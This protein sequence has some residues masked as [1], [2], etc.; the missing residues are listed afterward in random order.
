MLSLVRKYINKYRLLSEEKPVVVGLSGG[1]DSVA[2]LSVLSRLGYRCIA[3]H[4]NFHLR[5]NEAERDA[6]FACNF[7]QTLNIPFYQTGFDTR[8][9]AE[10]KHISV[11]MAARELRYRWF[12]D[13]RRQSDAQAIAVAHH[14]DDNVETFLINLLR[15]AGVRGLIGMRP[16]N[17]YIVRPLLSVS[18]EDLLVWLKE[19]QLSFI[20]DSSNLSDAYLRN[21]LRLNVLPLLEKL[22]PSVKETIAR[23]S[24]HL[25]AAEIIYRAVVK[26]A[27]ST[28]VDK[29]NRISISA[30][31]RFPSPETIL[32]ELL[33]PFHF[34]RQ[35]TDDICAALNKKASGKTFYS[36]THRLIKDRDYLL[37]T[38]MEQTETN[39][40]Y[41]IN[42]VEGI[43][44]GPV[45][46]SF[47]KTLVTD[48]FR[49]EKDKHMAYFDYDKL[50]FPLILR[51]WQAGDWFVP[52]GMKGRKKLSDYF[53]DRKYSLADK[54]KAWLLCSGE[55]IIWI[56]G[57]RTD[58][59]FKIEKT[60]KYALSIKFLRNMF[61]HI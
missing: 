22:N 56:V 29:D 1:A 17:G 47:G 50:K 14:R 30:L 46:L 45:E 13:L 9:Y 16:K 24:E 57:E 2:L 15:G 34:T 58:E 26:K 38:A 10:E 49:M 12:E 27:Q 43:W 4:C 11:E 28:V 25:A 20:T 31:L 42:M 44:N 23:T 39:R 6:T 51:T 21:F 52:F 41:L 7:A 61:A 18:R 40:T 8:R 60:T 36:P 5:G 48:T 54:E 19:Q 35:V 37:I 59:R 32:Y 3:A 55:S 53:S 33:T